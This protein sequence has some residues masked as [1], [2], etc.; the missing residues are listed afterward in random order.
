VRVLPEA[1]RQRRIVRAS[2]PSRPIGSIRPSTASALLG[3][4]SSGDMVRFA[5]RSSRR[6]ASH[7]SVR[8]GSKSSKPWL[9]DSPSPLSPPTEDSSPSTPSPATWLA[10]LTY[11]QC[12]GSLLCPRRVRRR[13]GASLSCRPLTNKSAVTTGLRCAIRTRTRDCHA[14]ER[15]RRRCIGRLRRR[16]SSSVLLTF[17]A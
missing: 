4:V 10:S 15:L 16:P 8:D 12:E 5:L 7:R 14:S 1:R 6:N 9:P 2:G 13:L 3:A 17:L 11:I